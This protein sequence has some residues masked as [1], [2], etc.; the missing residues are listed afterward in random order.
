[1]LHIIFKYIEPP[2]VKKLGKAAVSRFFCWLF[3]SL[4]GTRSSRPALPG[5]VALV[6]DLTVLQVHGTMTDLTVLQVYGKLTGD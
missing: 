1:M 2:A 3:V 5:M 6:T 4:R